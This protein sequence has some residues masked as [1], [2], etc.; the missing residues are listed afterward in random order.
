MKHFIIKN[1]TLQEKL[2][3]KS[4]IRHLAKHQISYISS[5][6]EFLRQI[7]NKKLK[8]SSKIIAFSS[9]NFWLKPKLSSTIKGSITKENASIFDMTFNDLGESKKEIEVMKTYYPKLEIYEG[10][11]STIENLFKIKSPKILHISTHGFFLDNKANPNPMLASGLAFAGANYANLK[12]DARGIATALQLSGLKLQNTELVVLSA[13]DTAL[14]KVHNAEGVTGLSKAF[15]QAGA[16]QVLMS[17]WKV[18]VVE[19]ITLMQYFYANIHAGNNYAT[20]LRQAKLQ[21]ITMHPYYWS[22]FIMSGI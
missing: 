1:H 14:G 10:N 12:D 2:K 19:T 18:S 7:N 6:K 22:A 13:C 11:N 8:N 3:G 16:K 15:I 20:A 4:N 21:M 5:G 9:P 17:L